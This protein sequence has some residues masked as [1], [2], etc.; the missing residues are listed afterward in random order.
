[1][2][3]TKNDLPEKVRV[4]VA[5]LLQERLADAI[6]LVSHAKQAHWN[7]KGPSFIALH[8]LFDKVYANAGD[9]ADLLAE[10]IAQ[11][12]GTVQGTTR[13]VAKQTQLPEYPQTLTNGREHAEALA[14]SLAYFSS[15]VRQG[16]DRADDM[17]DKATADIFTEISR[18][19][20][21]D[22]WFVEA[23]LQAD[24]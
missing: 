6:D 1:M 11:L 7:V 5:G 24:R 9:Y 16:I 13:A 19:V 20:D 12:G 23:H 22:L 15:V 10:R 18:G 17:G 3:K 8:E 4:N 14:H 2:N 21:K